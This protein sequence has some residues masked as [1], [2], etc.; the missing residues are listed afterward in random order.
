MRT[1]ILVCLVA[2][3]LPAAAATFTVTTVNDGGPGSLRQAVLAANTNAGLD[4]IAFNIAG[5]SYTISLG[6]P[7]L[8]L[9]NS[10]IVDG[11]TRRVRV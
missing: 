1:G 11:Y 8:I 10:T 6:A 4:T 5:Q 2:A 7:A 9:T 3:T